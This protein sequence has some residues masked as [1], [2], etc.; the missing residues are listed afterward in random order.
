VAVILYFIWSSLI[1]YFSSVYSDYGR[2]KAVCAR[3]LMH[4]VKIGR[5]LE[6]LNRVKLPKCCRLLLTNKTKMSINNPEIP[7]NAT[8]RQECLKCGNPRVVHVSKIFAP[9]NILRQK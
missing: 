9:A 4:L 2:F 6:S 7:P 5:F 8:I 3:L 1:I